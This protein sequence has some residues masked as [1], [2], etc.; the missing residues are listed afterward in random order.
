MHAH[1]VEG[2]ARSCPPLGRRLGLIAAV[3][4]NGTIGAGGGLPWSIPE[5]REW[6]ERHVRG[7]VLVLGRRSWE[8]T[9]AP[10]PGV[11]GSVVVSS[12]SDFYGPPTTTT[13][14]SSLD[15]ALRQAAAMAEATA[16]AAR[17]AEM[18]ATAATTAAEMRAT[19][20]AA[21]AEAGAMAAATT[22]TTATTTPPPTMTKMPT[23]AEA[24]SAM[25]TGATEPHTPIWIGG[26]VRLYREAMALER[27]KALYL[28]RVG[29]DVA[30]D[31]TFPTG[32]EQW[33]RLKWQSEHLPEIGAEYGGVTF[34]VWHDL[35]S[36][37]T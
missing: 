12:R 22:A 6:F 8:E 1:C 30:G 23:T 31:T 7:G 2:L 19:A 34:E 27:P 37:V 15:D 5:D 18:R 35:A 20:T 21:A 16:A 10:I 11:R 26:G 25:A 3:A 9:G 28:T 4:N 29:N 17:A 33:F 24:L 36:D 32:W 14:A 13:T